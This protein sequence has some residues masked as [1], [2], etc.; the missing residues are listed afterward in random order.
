MKFQKVVTYFELD[1]NENTTYQNLWDAVKV[2]LKGKFIALNAYMKKE[3]KSKINHL[4]FH[5][6]KTEKEEQIKSK[7]SRRKK[8]LGIAA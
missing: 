1:K 8:I 3:G 7:R 2:V 5:L 6:K 4:N